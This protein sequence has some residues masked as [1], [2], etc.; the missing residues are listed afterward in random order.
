MSQIDKS[1]QQFALV[2]FMTAIISNT[3]AFA[4]ASEAVDDDG[5]P[6]PVEQAIHGL[7][8][9]MASVA[10]R[11]AAT[12]DLFQFPA[13]SGAGDALKVFLSVQ[14][15]PERLAF[16]DTLQEGEL[17]TDAAALVTHDAALWDGSADPDTASEFPGSGAE[18][19]EARINDLIRAVALLLAEIGRLERKEQ[20]AMAYADGAEERAAAAP[21]R[22]D[23]H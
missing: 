21:P 23:V 19:G 4:A 5:N 22:A 1:L 3:H 2:N 8:T 14:E 17:A 15:N 11:D 7:A 20:A 18:D 9:N 12:N 13:G 6:V 16:E 10:L